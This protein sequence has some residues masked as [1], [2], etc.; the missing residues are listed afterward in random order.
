M[1]NQFSVIITENIKNTRIQIKHKHDQIQQ[2]SKTYL[3][4]D[5][6]SILLLPP[7][8]SVVRGYQ[9]DVVVNETKHTNLSKVAAKPEGIII[10][11]K[12][13]NY[14]VEEEQE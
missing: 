1:S 11:T 13:E 4:T 7:E 12:T 2:K 14:T 5:T 9:A 3:K 6:Q 8:M 10:N